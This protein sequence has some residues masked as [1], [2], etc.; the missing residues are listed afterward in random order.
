MSVTEA[1]DEVLRE[2]GLLSAAW[3]KELKETE[4]GGDTI[5]NY[6]CYRQ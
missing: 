5:A 2:R 4:F 3:S 1:I 6:E